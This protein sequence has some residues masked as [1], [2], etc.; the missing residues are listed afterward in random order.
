MKCITFDPSCK[1]FVLKAFEYTF[2]RDGF[3]VDTANAVVPAIDG[4]P[5]L[6]EDFAGVVKTD[7]GVRLVRAGIC[8][9]IDL[10][11]SQEKMT[12]HDCVFCGG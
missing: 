3:V 1:L 4:K 7:Q 5:V 11:D 2:N 12:S 9:I 10:L 6:I 8:G